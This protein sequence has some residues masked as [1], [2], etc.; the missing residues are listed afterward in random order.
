MATQPREIQRYIAQDGRVP[1]DEWFY[2][3]RDA[4]AKVKI[5][6]RFDRVSRGNLGDCRSGASHF[7]NPPHPQP[8]SHKV[9][10]ENSLFFRPSP[11]LG[12]GGNGG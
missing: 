4:N 9:R 7:C 8:L 3:L 6:A 10:G 2:S 5:E 12:E 1:F 11:A